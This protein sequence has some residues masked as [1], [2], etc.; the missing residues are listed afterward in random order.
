MLEE[1][2]HCAFWFFVFCFVFF[3]LF[4]DI[5]Y[6][7]VTVVF[8]FPLQPSAHISSLSTERLWRW[9]LFI[10]LFV[11]MFILIL[12]ILY[13]TCSFSALANLYHAFCCLYMFHFF[14][15][16]FASSCYIVCVLIGGF[17]R[18][19]TVRGRV[20]VCA[21]GRASVRYHCWG[22]GPWIHQVNNTPTHHPQMHTRTHY[23]VT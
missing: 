2:L 7:Y 21:F 13:L 22:S 8:F 23:T 16:F 9:D 12:S 11:I 10:Q 6:I 4:F 18:S 15:L 19:S 3:V 17:F 20:C 5:F 1:Y 14:K